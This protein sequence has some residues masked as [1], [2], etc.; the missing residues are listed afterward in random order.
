MNDEQPNEAAG[1]TSPNEPEDIKPKVEHIEETVEGIKSEETI[2]DTKGEE[3]VGGTKGEDAKGETS[4]VKEDGGSGENSNS[5]DD[6]DDDEDDVKVTIED[7]N[8]RAA[9]KQQPQ[10]QQPKQPTID[11]EASQAAL[12][13]DINSLEDKPWRKPGADLNDY[14]NYGFDESTWRM[15]C[16]RQKKMKAAFNEMVEV[17][18]T[19]RI[20]V[21]SD[22]NKPPHQHAYQIPVVTPH[23]VPP[24]MVV[25][26]PPHLQRDIGGGGNDIRMGNNSRMQRDHS[27]HRRSRS[28]H[29]KPSRNESS[30]H[31]SRSKDNK[32]RKR[33]RSRD[34]SHRRSS[35]KES[36]KRRSRSRERDDDRHKSKRHKS[37][38]RA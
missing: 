1:T 32:E 15:Y 3:A 38:R 17:Q 22:F 27:S 13:V 7:Y 16:D 37:S 10:T 34:S 11:F 5:D 26:P 8:F 29:P 30:R 28:P 4:D 2:G 25:P 23:V 24:P 9:Q 35:G 6:D 20:P 12:D 33:S 14:F 18:E 19:H 36:R 21:I 31:H